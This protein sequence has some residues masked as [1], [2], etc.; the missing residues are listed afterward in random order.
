MEYVI[1]NNI[2]LEQIKLLKSI[3]GASSLRLYI[4][5]VGEFALNL[6]IESHDRTICIK[7]IPNIASDGDDYPKLIIEYVMTP[8]SD[9]ELL[10]E[11]NDFE[12]ILILKD[13]IT[14]E[15]MTLVGRWKSISA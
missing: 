13:A 1:K 7:N 2:E 15:G 5:E 10:Y 14:W 4:E 12:S 11:G 9:C 3:E 8:S 6:F